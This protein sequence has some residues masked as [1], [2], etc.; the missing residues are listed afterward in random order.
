MK[1]EHLLGLIC[2]SGFVA[3]AIGAFGAHGLSGVQAKAWVATGSSQH[4]A[5]T[6][7]LLACVWLR[8]QGY[9]RARFAVPLFSLGILLFAGSLYALALGAPRA[10]AM[11]A[12]VGGLS[13]LGGWLCLAWACFSRKDHADERD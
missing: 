12:P 3:V 4:M 11:A 9:H 1:Q 6:F 7:A 10:L 5:H 2:V 13:L 8:V